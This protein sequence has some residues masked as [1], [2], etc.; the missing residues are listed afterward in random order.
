MPRTPS[1]A[2]SGLYLSARGGPGKRAVGELGVWGVLVNLPGEPLQVAE[3]KPVRRPAWG[4][5]LVSFI[6]TWFWLCL[7]PGQQAGWLAGGWR[8]AHGV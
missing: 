3:K 5:L 8:G 4:S 1:S 6:H 7:A 2:P